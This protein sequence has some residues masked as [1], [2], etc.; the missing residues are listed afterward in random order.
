MGQYNETWMATDFALRTKENQKRIEYISDMSVGHTAEL[1]KLYTL[2]NDDDAM[3]KT[4]E[5]L[6][7][8]AGSRISLDLLRQLFSMHGNFTRSARQAYDHL[9][10]MPPYMY[11][12]GTQLINSFLGLIV[13]PYER[14]HGESY[15]R[16]E[17]L[18]KGNEDYDWICN[19][20]DR[21][22]VDTIPENDDEFIY[23][24]YNDGRGHGDLSPESRARVKFFWKHLR[25]AFA[26]SGDDSLYF[27]PLSNAENIK[28]VTHIAFY[29]CIKHSMSDKQCYFLAK[30]TLEDV[31]GIAARLDSIIRRLDG[32]KRI[33]PQDDFEEKKDIIQQKRQSNEQFWRPSNRKL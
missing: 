9:N 11:F 23:S 20:I 5:M 6:S 17:A 16:L 27:F 14:F 15:A 28:D 4:S 25:N 22:Y 3:R 26:H 10:W 29:D 8:I 21:L 18:M 33:N 32:N 2:S 19:L 13:L 24:S 7:N 1:E 31:R 30:I 12:D